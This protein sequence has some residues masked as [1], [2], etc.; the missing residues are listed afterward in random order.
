MKEAGLPHISDTWTGAEGQ[1][2]L[3]GREDK[4]GSGR[5]G[6]RGTASLAM[7]ACSVT[8]EHLQPPQGGTPAACTSRPAS[9][10]LASP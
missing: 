9:L 1:R 5:E 6:I 7:G 10:P 4:K 2:E 3:P 8:S